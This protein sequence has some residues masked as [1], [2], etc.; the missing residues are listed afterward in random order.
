M[1]LRFSADIQKDYSG[2]YISTH[3]AADGSQVFVS[4][5]ESPLGALG[6][7]SRC[8]DSLI[9]Q[10]ESTAAREM[11]PCFDEPAM[12]AVFKVAITR[13]KVHSPPPRSPS[14]QRGS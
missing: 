2:L 13:E 9:T 7:G 8:R 6:T 3:E 10:F 4:S 1:K 11:F 14:R 5:H 12:K